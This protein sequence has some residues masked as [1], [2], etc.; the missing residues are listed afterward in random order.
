MV[1][2]STLHGR[3]YSYMVNVSLT[4][5]NGTILEYIVPSQNCLFVC[6]KELMRKTEELLFSRCSRFSFF[7]FFFNGESLSAYR[8]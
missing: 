4:F 7:F 3:W 2:F 6:K 8:E 1:R 5:D